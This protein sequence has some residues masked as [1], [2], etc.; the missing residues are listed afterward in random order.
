M[1]GGRRPQ[2]VKGV[3]GPSKVDVGKVQVGVITLDISLKCWWKGLL[4]RLMYSS[5]VSVR[6]SLVARC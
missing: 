4:E 3:Q 6:E 1:V 5:G 2:M